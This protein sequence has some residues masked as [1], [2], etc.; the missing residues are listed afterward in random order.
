MIQDGMDFEKE[1][2]SQTG[3]DGGCG[4]FTHRGSFPVEADVVEIQ[5][6]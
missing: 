3:P 5:E 1:E 6:T 2:R 4:I